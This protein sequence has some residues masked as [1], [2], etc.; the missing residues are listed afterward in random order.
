MEKSDP[1][2]TLFLYCEFKDYQSLS[3]LSA[4]LVSSQ[5]RRPLFD[6][7]VDGGVQVRYLFCGD[8]I[9]FVPVYLCYPVHILRLNY[10][11]VSPINT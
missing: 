7:H 11:Q 8:Q 5:H 9:N 6:K 3:N 4:S 2:A 10:N 1:F